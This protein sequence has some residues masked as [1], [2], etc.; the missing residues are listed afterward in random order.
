MSDE[1]PSKDPPQSAYLLA[2]L[3]AFGLLVVTMFA[4]PLW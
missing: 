2:F 4:Y 3:A 1:N